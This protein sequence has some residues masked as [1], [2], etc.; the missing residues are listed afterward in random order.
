M[1]NVAKY[2]KPEPDKPRYQS[3][4]VLMT[5]YWDNQMSL[6]AIADHF[7]ISRSTIRYWMDKRDVPVR[8]RQ[9]AYEANNKPFEPGE[10]G[11]RAEPAP[12][13][14]EQSTDVSRSDSAHRAEEP[15]ERQESEVSVSEAGRV[16][17]EEMYSNGLA[18]GEVAEKYSVSTE[19][20]IWLMKE[21]GIGFAPQSTSTVP[22]ELEPHLSALTASHYR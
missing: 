3:K 1:V 18:V 22:S 4:A 2:S 20:V 6:S 13:S 15:G 17:A 12:T 10:P 7:D 5:L 11:E 14:E 21:R 19:A 8:S 16:V 9:Q